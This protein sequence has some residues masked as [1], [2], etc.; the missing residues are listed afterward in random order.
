MAGRNMK[1]GITG[2]LP[3]NG[4][5]VD[6][7]E[8]FQVSNFDRVIPRGAWEDQPSRV[9]GSMSRILEELARDEVRGTFFILGWVA[10]RYPDLVRRIHGAGHEVASHGT[11]HQKVYDLTPD[12]FRQDVSEAKQ[13]L[14]DIIGEPVLGYRAPSYSITRLSW[15]ALEILADTGYRYDS[16]IFPIRHYRYGIPGYRRFPHRIELGKDAG[17]WEFPLTTVALLGLNFPIAGGAYLR[18]LPSSL[19]RCGLWWVNRREGKPAVIYFHPWEIDDGQPR[20]NVRLPIRINHYYNLS[21][22]LGKLQKIWRN[23]RFGPLREILQHSY[24]ME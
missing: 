11:G 1:N 21:R 5:T 2:Q 14:E 18:F 15:W 20:Q 16:S 7:E 23:G 13:I 6:V 17:I 24:G 9:Q 8:Y 12:Q 4:L 3:V 19:V 22:M 10:R